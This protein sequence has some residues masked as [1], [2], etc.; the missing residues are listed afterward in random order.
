MAKP[1]RASRLFLPFFP[2]IRHLV[3]RVQENAPGKA[4]TCNYLLSFRTAVFA[5]GYAE[6]EGDFV[7]PPKDGEGYEE[8]LGCLSRDDRAY[9]PPFR[10]MTKFM[11]AHLLRRHK[12]RPLLRRPAI[13]PI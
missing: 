1:F 13:A 4:S 7:P 6:E 12:K 9:A 8:R 3:A 2:N 5:D 10:G 11:I